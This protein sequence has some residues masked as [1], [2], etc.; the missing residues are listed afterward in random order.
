MATKKKARKKTAAKASAAA[1]GPVTLAQAKTLAKA[2]TGPKPAAKKAVADASVRKVA[3]ER[4]RLE[5]RT[6]ADLKQR[7]KLYEETY[8]VMQERGVKGLAQKPKGP[9]M[10]APSAPLRIM[11][12]GDSWFDYP[13]PFFGGGVVE[14][15]E[16]KL[17]LPI[18]SSAD[19]GD[20]VR[21]ML[22]VKQ[23]A[24]L[25]ALFARANQQGKPWDVLLFS[26]GGNDIVD[27]PLCLWVRP[28]AAGAPPDAL[29]HKARFDAALA[30]VRA[31][32]EDLIAMRDRLSP[33]TRLVFHGYDFA[34][35]TGKGVCTLGPWL[36]PAFDYHGYPNLAAR[37]AVVKRVL[38]QFAQTLAALEASHAANVSFINAQGTL[39]A[40]ADWWHNELHPNQKGFDVFV[41]RFD[42][43]LRALY[44]GRFP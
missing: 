3:D 42:Q 6:R 13:V 21:F 30:I 38:Q 2:K 11:A 31:G 44:P 40:H 20:E 15:L 18:L 1:T 7:I 39:D 23:R 5:L 29:I 43:T 35:P 8:A 28:W 41:K 36:K 27:E 24:K 33:G 16:K 37:A 12:E 17:G 22:G 9:G 19:A 26:G 4:R 25:E 10:K 34:L 14:R 32:Y